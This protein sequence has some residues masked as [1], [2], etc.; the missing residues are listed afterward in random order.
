MWPTAPSMVSVT[1][2]YD[3]SAA[4][5]R[6]IAV[7]D[8]WLRFMLRQVELELDDAEEHARQIPHWRN[9]TALSANLSY[10]PDELLYVAR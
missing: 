1:G 7:L 6:D 9:V 5:R 8:R 4:G 2:A 3:A 10:K